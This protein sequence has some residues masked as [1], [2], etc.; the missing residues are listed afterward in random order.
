MAQIIE[1]LAPRTFP[2]DFSKACLIFARS[3]TRYSFQHCLLWLPA[4]HV[5]PVTTPWLIRILLPKASATKLC[6]EISVLNSTPLITL[7][8]PVPFHQDLNYKQKSILFFYGQITS[9]VPGESQGNHKVVSFSGWAPAN[10][11]PFSS[12]CL[13]TVPRIYSSSYAQ[14]RSSLGRYN[15]SSITSV[16]A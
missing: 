5:L 9:R 16:V 10:S 2:P 12:I 6:H 11:P 14:P 7:F 3:M 13:H 4:F 8:L 1:P 15:L